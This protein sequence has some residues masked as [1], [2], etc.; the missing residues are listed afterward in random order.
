MN[1][2]KSVITD[3]KIMIFEYCCMCVV[4]SDLECDQVRADLG[5]DLFL[6]N[7]GISYRWIPPHGSQERAQVCSW[8]FLGWQDLTVP[9]FLLSTSR[10]SFNLLGV[11]IFCVY[12]CH[13]SNLL[14]WLITQG[15]CCWP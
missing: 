11:I 13:L 5:F 4:L 12:S 3:I 1:I 8:V 10:E 14:I 6:Q 9:N 7:N 2:A 15:S